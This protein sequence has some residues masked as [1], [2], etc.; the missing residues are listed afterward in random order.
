MLR[1]NLVGPSIYIQEG[2]WARSSGSKSNSYH[3]LLS[4]V[5]SYDGLGHDSRRFVE[6][7]LNY[8]ILL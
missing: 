1:E 3:F 5:G 4:E 2:R 6:S 8:W 7:S